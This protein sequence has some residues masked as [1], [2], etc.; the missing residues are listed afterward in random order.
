MVP[1]NWPHT[2]VV[3]RLNSDIEDGEETFSPHTTI[4]AS[5]DCLVEPLDGYRAQTVFGN[6]GGRKYLV[7]WGTEV[8]LPEDR[9][10]IFSMVLTYYPNDDDQYRPT[11]ETGIEPY[12]TGYLVED[13]MQKS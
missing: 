13:A 8:I 10:E 1:V 9:F 3:K 4:H 11:D 6:F 7:S 5:L 12:Q 2:A